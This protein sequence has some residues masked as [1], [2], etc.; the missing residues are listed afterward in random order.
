M[1][2]PT[3]H[4]AIYEGSVWHARELPPAH[5]FR[6]RLYMLLLDLDELPA[7]ARTT[8]LLG[9]DR[10]RPVELRTRDHFR[11]ASRDLR[12][13]LAATLSTRGLPPPTGAVRVLTQGRVL[14][15]GFNPVSFWWAYD[16]HGALVAC[17]AEVNNTFG[18]RHP[19]VLPA[20]E[21][22]RTDLGLAW[23]VRKRLHVSPFMDL[24]GSYR[25][26]LSEPAAR[27]TVRATLL[28]AGAVRLRAGFDAERTPLSNRTLLGA[29]ARLP[30]M[31]WQ[32]WTGI[33]AQAVALWRKGARYHPRPP[34]DP[35]H[36]DGELA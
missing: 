32:V 31:P 34:Y 10:R 30:G 18:D 9:A 13:R 12:T 33:H 11:A 23:T 19:Y 3:P 21:A 15:Q 29:L 27:L 20:A 17:V 36:V 7:L 2:S 25:F 1:T 14:G 6:R 35:S 16:R 8:S 26:E 24:E 22:E 28:R 4:S 5:A